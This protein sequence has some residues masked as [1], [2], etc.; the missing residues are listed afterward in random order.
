MVRSVFSPPTASLIPI[1]LSVC[2][3]VCAC[4]DVYLHM[5]TN[6]CMLACIM[7][8]CV[9]L[10]MHICV[11]TFKPSSGLMFLKSHKISI[12]KKMVVFSVFLPENYLDEVATWGSKSDEVDICRGYSSWHILNVGPLSE[13][14]VT[15]IFPLVCFL[16]NL[17]KSLFGGS[18][19]GVQPLLCPGLKATPS[20]VGKDHP[21]WLTGWPTDQQ[22]GQLQE[23]STSGNGEGRE[24]LPN[25]PIRQTN[26]GHQWGN[27]H[28]SQITLA[29]SKC[30]CLSTNKTKTKQKNLLI[31][32]K[33]I[34]ILLP[35]SLLS[36]SRLWRFYSL[37]FTFRW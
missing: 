19:S 18:G 25:Q 22:S 2:A 6:I 24:P 11:F 35:Q 7:F 33:Y 31:L 10:H 17:L 1:L 5:S 4:M 32:I 13:A 26:P 27:R 21:L 15:D 9:H 36:D 14:W 12:S 23:G 37:Y 29:S 8:V 30:S 3:Y 20:L 28:H 16:L 34:N